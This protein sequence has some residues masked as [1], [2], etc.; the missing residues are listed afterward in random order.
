MITLVQLSENDKRVLIALFIGLIIIFALIGLLVRHLFA[1]FNKQSRLVDTFMYDL[2]KLKIVEDTK[3]FKRVAYHKSRYHFFSKSW[4]PILIMTVGWVIIGV[5]CLVVGNG[6]ISFLFSKDEG[7][8]TL[9]F[10]FDWKNIPKSEFFGI[11]L[12]SEWP[13]ILVTENGRKCTPQ[14]LY[15]NPR[16]W[17]SY[18]SIPLLLTGFIW[19]LCTVF[20]LIARTYR[21]RKMSIETFYKN[22]D[23]LTEGNGVTN[24]EQK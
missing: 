7:I 1:S 22:L 17:I 8:L 16:A 11:K 20:C 3:H 10:L 12:P 18:I 13:P 2:V 5:Y 15:D 19:Y 24:T 9:F 6:D 14:F 21:I 4:R 23:N